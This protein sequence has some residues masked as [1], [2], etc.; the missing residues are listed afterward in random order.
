MISEDSKSE[1]KMC[2]WEGCEE[3][4]KYPAPK[5]RDNSRERYYFCLK[6]IRLYNES[7]DFFKGMSEQQIQQ[8]QIDSVV[9]HRQ[10]FKNNFNNRDIRDDI[11]E[12]FGFKEFQNPKQ[13]DKSSKKRL[14]T[15]DIKY[16]KILDLKTGFTAKELKAN[17]KNLAKKYHPDLKGDLAKFQLISE[18]YNYFKE[19]IKNERN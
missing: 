15:K 17:Y 6:H 7:W 11:Y 19:K 18:A 2:D 12:E 3:G 9:G 10:T 8:F 1:A 5:S 14:S 4:G 13:K 16:A